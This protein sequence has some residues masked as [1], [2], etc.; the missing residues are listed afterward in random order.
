MGEL[1]GAETPAEGGQVVKLEDVY[2]GMLNDSRK[3]LF[4]LLNQMGQKCQAIQTATEAGDLIALKLKLAEGHQVASK[5]E[6]F[7]ANAEVKAD[8]LTSDEKGEILD[9]SVPPSQRT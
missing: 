7:F 9:L 5:L 4:L 6:L 2:Q 8:A 3:G 1:P